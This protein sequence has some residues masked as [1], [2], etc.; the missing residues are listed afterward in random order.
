MEEI[1]HLGGT[2]VVVV[3]IDPATK[4]AYPLSVNQSG[5]LGSATEIAH[6]QVTVDTT[7]DLIV[8]ARAGRKSV[9]IMNHGNVDVYIGN[10]NVTPSTGVLLVG[11]PGAALTIDTSSAIYGKTSSDSSVVSYLEVY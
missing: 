8:A 5:S 1:T 4:K 6:N 3:G 7:G 11:I 9:L 10:I 2:H